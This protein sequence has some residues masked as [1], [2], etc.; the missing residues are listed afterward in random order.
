LIKVTFKPRFPVELVE[1]MCETEFV[2]LSKVDQR[3]EDPRVLYLE[4]SVE[5]YQDLKVQLEDS[6]AKAHSPLPNGQATM[7]SEIGVTS[8]GP[9]RPATRDSDAADTNDVVSE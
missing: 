5:Q 9:Q 6:S 3:D 7:F 1:R 2:G 8:L 4:P